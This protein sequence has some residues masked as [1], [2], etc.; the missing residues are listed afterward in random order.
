[1]TAA[2][3]TGA[4]HGTYSG[5]QRHLADDTPACDE[6]KAATAAYHRSRRLR[7]AIESGWT[8]YASMTL[9]NGD[10]LVVLLDTDTLEWKAVQA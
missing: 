8:E 3:F 10:Q 9:P 6:C 7:K 5:Y 2:T 4:E 1:M